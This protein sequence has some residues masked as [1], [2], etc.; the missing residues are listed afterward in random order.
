MIK[1]GR[2]IYCIC[3]IIF[4]VG[5]NST[6]KVVNSPVLIEKESKHLAFTQLTNK[7]DF[8]IIDSNLTLAVHFYREAFSLMEVDYVSPYYNAYIA[9]SEIRDCEMSYYCAKH[10][11]KFGAWIEH[12]QKNPCLVDDDYLWTELEDAYMISNPD[13]SF[14][15]LLKP[16][17]N[18]LFRLFD[19]RYQELQNLLKKMKTDS[20][21]TFMLA[22]N[23]RVGFIELSKKQKLKKL[24]SLSNIFVGI[25]EKNGFPSER[26]L[27]CEWSL[28]G[29]S[30]RDYS[31]YA[32]AY[33][34]NNKVRDI[35]DTA[36]EEGLIAAGE[37][38]KLDSFSQFY[39][40]PIFRIDSLHAFFAL[41]FTPSEITEIN[42][43]R[44]QIALPSLEKQLL[45]RKIYS[46]QSYDSFFFSWLGNLNFYKPNQRNRN[47]HKFE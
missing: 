46:F 47:F 6:K 43:R 39:V 26:L 12:F 19:S 27:G 32:S 30:F 40:N 42:L 21:D 18:Q 3:I 37:Y 11:L 23:N 44:E 16:I 5:C 7:A 34:R 4:L 15:K 10:L 31:R 35:F 9:A 38:A 22:N 45:A 1:V 29:I 8:A 33:R 36:F 28:A 20:G 13:S 25:V 24:D 41:E 17:D 2:I 14:E